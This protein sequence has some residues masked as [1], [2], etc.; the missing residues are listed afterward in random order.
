VPDGRDACPEQKAVADALT[1]FSDGCDSDVYPIEGQVVFK[2]PIAFVAG[3]DSLGAESQPH[4]AALA[5]L[6]IAHEELVVKVQVHAE[7][8][9]DAAATRLLTELRAAAL[10]QTLIDQGVPA[11]RIGAKGFG[12]DA[13]AE[14]EPNER[15]VFKLVVVMPVAGE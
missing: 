14:G 4:L 6:L 10:R 12:S 15:I 1:K 2:Q 9:K 8:G 13:P 5:K 11:T 7:P 3:T